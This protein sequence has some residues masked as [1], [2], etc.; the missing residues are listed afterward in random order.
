MAQKKVNDFFRSNVIVGA[1][2]ILSLQCANLLNYFVAVTRFSD[3]V[4]STLSFYFGI[5]GYLFFNYKISVTK[6]N[7]IRLK[8][9]NI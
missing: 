6:K 8:M 9:N 7:I 4:T 1:L 5:T 3:F 2:N